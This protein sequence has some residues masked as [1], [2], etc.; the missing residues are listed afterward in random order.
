MKTVR[1]RSLRGRVSVAVGRRE[2]PAYQSRGP[3][4]PAVT[5]CQPRRR[6]S[7]REEQRLR[8]L[9]PEVAA[10]R[11]LRAAESWHSAPSLPAR[12]VG[13]EPPSDGPRVPR[14]PCAGPAVSHRSS[15]RTLHRIAWFCLSLGEDRP[16][17]VEVDESFRQRPAYQEGCL[18]DEPDLSRYDQA[19]PEDDPDDPLL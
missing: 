10:Y 2:E 1:R 8:A 6:D 14:G 9:G 12:A 3:T 17:D 18:T 16:L 11:R 19:L 4:P 15:L 7:Q 5:G 13:L